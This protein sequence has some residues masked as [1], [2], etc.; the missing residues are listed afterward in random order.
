[1][2]GF[3]VLGI[4]PVWMYHDLGPKKEWM[5]HYREL[6]LAKYLCPKFAKNLYRDF[7]NFDFWAGDRQAPVLL[8]GLDFHCDSYLLF[9]LHSD[10]VLNYEKIRWNCQ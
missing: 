6:N 7:L 9:L 1:M 8:H 3:G 2:W 10:E 4:R 5:Y